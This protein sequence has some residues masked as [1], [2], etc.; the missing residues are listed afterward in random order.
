MAA[1]LVERGSPLSS[2]L[3]QYHKLCINWKDTLQ[4]WLAVDKEDT[5]NKL[6]ESDQFS[7]LATEFR[8]AGVVN[9][10]EY[11]YSLYSVT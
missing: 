2:P 11:V 9:E 10:P 8:D 7:M 6:I 1:S 4:T 3:A 5:I